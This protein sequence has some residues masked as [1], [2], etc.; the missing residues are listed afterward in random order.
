MPHEVFPVRPESMIFATKW[1]DPATRVLSRH[2]HDS[3]R[4]QAGA[5]HDHTTLEDSSRCGYAPA[6]GLAAQGVHLCPGHQLDPALSKNLVEHL[7]HSSV[8]SDSF[9]RDQDGGLR[10][11]VRL[12]L[13]GCLR[14]ESSQAF[15]A[16]G[17]ATVEHLVEAGQFGL[18]RS[19]HELAANF[20]LHVVRGAELRHA[21]N[22]LAR[23]ASFGRAWSIL[24]ARVKHPAVVRTLVLSQGCF[25][26]QNANTDGALIR[27]S[28]RRCEADDAASDDCDVRHRTDS[29]VGEWV[30][31]HVGPVPV[32]REVGRGSLAFGFDLPGKA[33]NVMKWSSLI[34]LVVILSACSANVDLDF[35]V[36]VQ[37]VDTVQGPDGPQVVCTVVV[38]A[39][40]VGNGG[41]F[42]RFG[43]AQF[44]FRS[45]A[46]GETLSSEAV[47]SA[48]MSTQF[49]SQVIESG[50]S[51]QSRALQ[52]PASEG[53]HWDFVFFYR[54]PAGSRSSVEATARCG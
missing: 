12:Y 11:H 41:Q 27:Q 21:A 6:P 28:V 35:D 15:Q 42:A 16:V 7:T 36:A 31:I 51:L 48:F 47:S 3:V 4:V 26:L 8:I 24:E 40:A 49:N 29:Q 33:K 39:T 2:R 46:S 20:V 1:Y 50:N 30:R 53:F 5:V 22:A 45:L 38:T 17:D 14:R 19:H 18:R 43:E 54:N 34:V 13:P 23:E 25:L 32:A 10:M 52:R 9:L 37:N 44:T